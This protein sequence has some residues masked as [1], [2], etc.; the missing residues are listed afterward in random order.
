M[1]VLNTNTLNT[2]D[3]S[4]NL[5]NES[6]L[7]DTTKTCENREL[8]ENSKPK[9]ATT[10]PTIATMP[11]ATNPMSATVTVLNSNAPFPTSDQ[12]S[13]SEEDFDRTTRNLGAHKWIFNYKDVSS[14]N[15]SIVY[16]FQKCETCCAPISSTRNCCVRMRDK[17]NVY[18]NPIACVTYKEV[19]KVKKNMQTWNGIENWERK[20]KCGFII[21]NLSEIEWRFYWSSD[22]RH[23][24]KYS[25][26]NASTINK[27]VQTKSIYCGKM[28]IHFSSWL[29][30]R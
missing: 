18:E 28:S 19:I 13:D 2:V 30:N 27:F 26:E 23:I 22:V 6:H 15:P 5:A 24:E 21:S 25:I 11:A 20:Q 9:T 17:L 16:C 12:C 29:I 4:K 7:N 10:A 14:T 3:A 8:N 1:S